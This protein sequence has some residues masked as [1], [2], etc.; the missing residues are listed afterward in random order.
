[1]T[2]QDKQYYIYLRSTRERIPCTKEEFD[3]YYRDINA[4]RW[5]QQRHGRCVC[6]QNKRLDCDMDCVT[7]PFYRAGDKLSLDY[8]VEDED[9]NEKAWVEDLKDPSTAMEEIVTNR[10]LLNQLLTRINELMPYAIQIGELRQKGFSE[11]AIA[12]EIGIGRK[13]Y[14]YRLKKLK[15]VLEI[16]F[17]EI[18]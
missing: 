11:D 18:F 4:Y 3:N 8:T 15:A 2:N 7:C 9:G 12:A 16:E 13:T 1:M 17:P 10:I 14:A 5:K 6:P